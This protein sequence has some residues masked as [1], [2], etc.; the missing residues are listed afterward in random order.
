MTLTASQEANCLGAAMTAYVALGHYDGFVQAA[1]SMIE[2]AD[3]VDPDPS[4]V[5]IY[6]E[7]SELFRKAYEQVA[8][9]HKALAY[10][11]K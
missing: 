10:R 2:V 1:E 6:R 11:A 9:I 3:Q 8:P 7:R 4:T 5:S